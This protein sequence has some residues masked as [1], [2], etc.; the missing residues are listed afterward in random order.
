MALPLANTLASSLGPYG[1]KH[2]ILFCVYLLAV[3]LLVLVVLKLFKQLLWK[4][5]VSCNARLHSTQHVR[6]SFDLITA[7]I[8][9][10][11]SIQ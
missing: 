6:H 5:N 9:C 7:T 4:S 10:A 11:L 2:Y 3:Y 1:L 8:H